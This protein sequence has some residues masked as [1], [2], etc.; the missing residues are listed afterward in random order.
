MTTDT[1]APAL[2]AAK[3][4]SL[5]PQSLDEAMAFAKLMAQ[6]SIIPKDYQ[7]NPGNVLVAVQWGMELGLQPL[8]AMQ[9]IAVINGRPS[10][11]GDAMLALVRGSG[12]LE[13]IQEDVAES[14]ATCTVK[15]KGEP[16]VT[17]TFTAD[18]AKKASLWGKQ[19]P[20]TQYPKRMLQMRA[21]AFALRDVFADV[22]RGIGIAEEAQ[23]TE[24]DMGAAHVVQPATPALPLASASERLKAKVAERAPKKTDLKKVLDAIIAAATLEAL[25]EV[26]ALAAELTDDADKT[27]AREA[28]AKRQAELKQ[29]WT[30]TPEELEA[31]RQ[32]ELAEAQKDG[33][34]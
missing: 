7:G 26:A 6:A 31:I 11:Y 14:A 13:Y 23:D 1:Q 22:L 12:L 10:I 5:T 2:H 8:Q 28:Y 29:G 20:W 27:K 25:S 21:R 19:G 33:A 3:P 34:Q 18:D 17:R 4:F 16:E 9:N 24:R 15:R 32:R 30:P